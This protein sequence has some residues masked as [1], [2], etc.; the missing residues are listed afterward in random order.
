MTA[1][2]KLQSAYNQCAQIVKSSARNFYYTFLALPK[3][4]RA[5]INA[6][7]AFCRLVDDAADEPGPIG[8]K[9]EQLQAYRTEFDAALA[10]ASRQPVLMAVSD[11]IHRYDIP[12]HLFHELIDGVT[13]DLTVRRYADF[14]SMRQYCYLVAS[15]V[16][17]MCLPIFGTRNETAKEHGVDLGIALQITNILRDVGEDVSRDRIYLPQED[18]KAHGYSEEEL[19][20]GVVND[21][22]RSLVRQQIER[23]RVYYRSG[24]ELLKYLPERTRSCPGLMYEVYKRILDLIEAADFDVFTQ[25]IGPSKYEKLRMVGQAWKQAVLSHV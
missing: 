15:T 9:A 7:Y 17:L 24:K 11:T 1:P 19:K 21:A 18:L 23:A 25:R 13:Q 14:D 6:I 2:D 16:G 8:R 5:A 20:T 3:E 10:G 12:P 22:F 4:E